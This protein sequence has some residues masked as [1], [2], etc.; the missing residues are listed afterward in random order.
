MAKF[1]NSRNF[2]CENARNYTRLPDSP[3]G[4]DPLFHSLFHSCGNLG[5]ETQ[6]QP[7]P[8]R[9]QPWRQTR[10]CSTGVADEIKTGAFVD[11]FRISRLVLEVLPR[12]GADDVGL[13]PT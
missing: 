10:E 9:P 6:G 8:V 3:S 7:R 12:V 13:T 5:E 4:S 11:T 2:P 1:P